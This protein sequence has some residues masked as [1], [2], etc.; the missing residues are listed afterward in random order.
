MPRYSVHIMAHASK[1]QQILKSPP[2]YYIIIQI[3]HPSSYMSFMIQHKGTVGEDFV[4][5]P[6]RVWGLGFSGCFDPV[7]P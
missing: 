2:T 3:K 6:D 4:P 7:T 1:L 5:R